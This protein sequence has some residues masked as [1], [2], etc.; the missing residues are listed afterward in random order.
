M[1]DAQA[2]PELTM[3]EIYAEWLDRWQCPDEFRTGQIDRI[4]KFCFMSGAAIIAETERD[5]LANLGSNALT[6]IMLTKLR[7]VTI[8]SFMQLVDQMKIVA[9]GK[10][11]GTT[12]AEL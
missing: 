2:P 4:I 5:I 11:D 1:A 8:A 10:D 6:D 9:K 12:N 3:D 7:E